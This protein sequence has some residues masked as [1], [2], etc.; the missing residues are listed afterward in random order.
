MAQQNVPSYGGQAVIEGVMFGGKQVTVTAIRRKNQEIEYF[1][2]PR[3]EIPWVKALKKIPFL[4][5]IVGLI[6]ASANGAKHLNFASDRY[7]MESDEEVSAGPSRLQMILGVAVV[8]ILSFLFGKFVFTLVPVFLADFLFGKWITN[9]YAQNI[10]EGVIKLILLLGY[11]TA[12]AQAPLIKRLFQYHGAEHK[13]INAYES[14]VDLTVENVQKFSTLHY[15]CG[16]SFLIFTVIIGVVIYS[17]FS[18]DSLWERVVQRIVLLPV[19]LGV[20]YEVLQFTNKLRDTPVLRFL[21]YPGLWLQKITTREPDDSQVEVAI[22]AFNKMR[23]RDH[24][25]TNPGLVSAG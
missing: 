1:E 2:A 23:E 16:S 13:V 20:S 24:E 4:R 6:E 17:F 7:S 11:I 19:V 25:M 3:N 8:G 12:I 14:G 15:R 10:L 5:G 9:Q 18:Y 22:A 21:G